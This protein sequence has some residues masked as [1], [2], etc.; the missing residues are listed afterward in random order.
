MNPKAV[1]FLGFFLALFG[2]NRGCDSDPEFL[3]GLEGRM[4]GYLYSFDEFGMLLEDHSGFKVT[5]RGHE[6]TYMAFSDRNGRF[7]LTD[8]P[9]GTYELNFW[10]PGFG[11]L[12]QFG[13][14]H[15]GGKATILLLRNSYLTGD[16]T[17]AYFLYEIANT[18]IQDLLIEN[19]TLT[20]AFWFPEEVQPEWA[21]IVLYLSTEEGFDIQEAQHTLP[22]YLREEEGAYSAVMGFEGLPFGGGEKIYCRAAYFTRPWEWNQQSMYLYELYGPDSYFDYESNQFIFPNRGEVSEQYSFVLQE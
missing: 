22:L 1:L 21:S 16:Q 6:G 2:L 11:I 10:K 14:Q 9:T 7:E 12:Q 4:V 15:L 13:V 20:A 17:R 19:D 3:P 8:M 18:R 5:A